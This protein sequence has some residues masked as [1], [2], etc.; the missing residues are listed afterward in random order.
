MNIY[1]YSV[2]IILIVLIASCGPKSK[3]K[4]PDKTIIN[5]KPDAE[6]LPQKEPTAPLPAIPAIP[7][8]P[9]SCADVLD[10]F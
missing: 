7:G 2:F 4:S 9:E 3:P 6:K 8:R 5:T 10:N 1:K